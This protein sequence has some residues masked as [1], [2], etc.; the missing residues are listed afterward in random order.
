MT[1]ASVEEFYG[2]IDGNYEDARA[3]LCSDALITRILAKFLDDTTC[4]NLIEAWNRGDEKAAFDAAHAAKGVCLNLSFT[5]L[6]FLTSQITEALRPGNE[7]L[8]ANIN[9]DALVKEVE[10]E[11]DKVCS[12]IKALT[13]S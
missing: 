4:P 7:E 10:T 12:G 3:R 8:R 9:G 11:Y 6:G 5:Q 2:K 1:A 13:A